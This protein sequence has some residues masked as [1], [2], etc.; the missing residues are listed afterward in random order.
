M[1]LTRLG[2]SQCQ[3][4]PRDLVCPVAAE[5][6]VYS[7]AP[8]VLVAA[9]GGNGR[10]PRVTGWREDEPGAEP[11][12]DGRLPRQVRVAPIRLLVPACPLGP[13]GSGGRRS[14]LGTV[15]VSG[16]PANF[17]L[18][19]VAANLTRNPLDADQPRLTRPWVPHLAPSKRHP[20]VGSPA[21]RRCRRASVQPMQDPS[22]RSRR[23]TIADIAREAGVSKGAVSY[24]LNGLPG[25]SASTRARV[26]AI[27]NELGWYPNRAARSLS[28]AR[29]DACGLVVARAARMLALEPFFMELI[30]GVEAEFSARGVA[31]MIQLAHDPAEEIEVYRRWWAERRV[32]G[33]MM[34]N[35]R[36][37]DPRVPAL[38]ELGL[39]AVVVGGPIAG[40]PAAG[41][42]E[43]RGPARRRGDPLPR[44]ARPPPRRARRRQPRLR[45]HGQPQRR[46]PRDHRGARALRRGGRHRL[47][48]GERRA[49]DPEAPLL[50]RPAHRDPLRQRHP[51]RDRPRR[52]P[53][54]G[55]LRSRTTSRSSPA[56]TRSSAASSTRR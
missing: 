43:R 18:R 44:R 53:P 29:A 21:P 4:E 34:V 45:P 6:S 56:T 48:A 26:L 16:D 50:A 13:D 51:R 10:P 41:R 37:D 38:V 7:T 52:R 24:A 47:H 54:D 30:A 17:R 3:D 11:D 28:A 9:N 42:L 25:V 39:P 14:E 40:G 32:D 20:A 12:R 27:A 31:L 22:G 15:V 2:Q 49:G 46:V 5:P 19:R 1:R 36:V 23:V 33:V 8:G 35:L 55:A